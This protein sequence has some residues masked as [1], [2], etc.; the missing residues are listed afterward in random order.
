M[1]NFDLDKMLKRGFILSE[2]ELEQASRI[3]R[4][5]RV[6]GKDDESFRVK[7]KKLRKLIYAYE[8]ENWSKKSK[9]SKV[10]LKESNEAEKLA[11]E[12][13]EFISNRKKLIKNKLSKLRLTQQEFGQILG[14]NSKS[15]ISELMNGVSP[16]TLRDLILISKLLSI[17]LND[18]VFTSISPEDRKRVEEIIRRLD[19]PNLKLKKKEFALS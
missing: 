4:K 12:Y 15:Y 9:I 5:L 8:T 14:H 13:S 17:N 10:Q 11:D 16:F 3:E 18:L 19:N 1:E 6:L 7:R 2:L